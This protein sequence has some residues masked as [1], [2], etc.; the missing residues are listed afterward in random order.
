MKGV[1]KK[2]RAPKAWPAAACATLTVGMNERGI[3]MVAL[4]RD[5]RVILKYFER[6][7]PPLW[8]DQ[9]ERF[10]TE[11]EM[12]QLLELDDASQDAYERA[13]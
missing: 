1:R 11:E 6:K 7:G 9:E 3:S 8:D 5:R 4:G 13:W 2:K 12:R 10:H